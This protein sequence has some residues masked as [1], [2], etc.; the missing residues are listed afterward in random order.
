MLELQVRHEGD[1]QQA[2]FRQVVGTHLVPLLSATLSSDSGIPTP[3]EATV[4]L[5]TPC[6]LRIRPLPDSGYH[7]F[8]DRS[9]PFSPADTQLV[10]SFLQEVRSVASFANGGYWRDVLAALPRR[11][12]VRH[13]RGSKHLGR[14]L[15]HMELWSSQTYEGQR[16]TS[17]VG[18]APQ[19]GLISVPVKEFFAQPFAPVLGDGVETL[20]VCGT[21]GRLIDLIPLDDC[22]ASRRA[23]FRFAR[24]AGWSAADKPAVVLNR[25]GEILVFASGTLRFSRR[26][27]QWLHYSHDA[28]ISRMWPPKL[29]ELR[30]ALYESCLD[31]SFARTGACLG[32]LAAERTLGQMID[33]ADLLQGRSGPKAK[34]FG[35]I[36][37]TPFQ[38]IDRRLRQEMLALDGA[39]VLDHRG[40]VLA[41]GAIVN[42]PA[43]S[44]AGGR[45]AAAKELSTLGFGIKVSA[46]GPISG[47][48][49]KSL[50][51][52]AS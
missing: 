50:V 23:P 3:R 49:D 20:L 2:T 51:F 15:E 28:I 48:R 25:H 8:V 45:Q 17:A 40:R 9:Q 24:V 13:L 27:G 11:V 22:K 43:G 26:R 14:I 47:Y 39:T 1:M 35:A 42:V 12:I 33:A 16:I 52:S 29:K 6:R 19:A 44:E 37:R 7:V 46:D 36:L 4:A 10:R 18:M 41:V 32:I 31:V 30:Q 21:D 34:L 38:G 5:P